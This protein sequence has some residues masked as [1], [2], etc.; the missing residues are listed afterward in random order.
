MLL[1]RPSRARSSAGCEQGA[2][3]STRTHR[4]V[5]RRQTDVSGRCCSW[6]P[7]IQCG[8]STGAVGPTS[9]AAPV[10]RQT[11]IESCSLYV[12]LCSH[13]S[14]QQ[15]RD[16][17]HPVPARCLQCLPP[18]CYL[19]VLPGSSV[20]PCSPSNSCFQTLWSS[21]SSMLFSPAVNITESPTAVTAR[22]C[23]TPWPAV[24]RIY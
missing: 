17:S 13:S 21:N 5:P 16:C 15:H 3:S 20:E 12:L 6:K 9:W 2:P 18:A 11:Y 22:H 10:S 8:D 7:H 1:A 19:G 4:R 24:Q 14:A 23:T